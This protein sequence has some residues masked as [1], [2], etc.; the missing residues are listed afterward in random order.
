MTRVAVVT[1]SRAD[2]AIYRPV[3][4]ALAD[5]PGIDPVLV[6]VGMHLSAAHGETVR[7]IE[8]DGYPI[9]ARIP[10]PLEDDTPGGTTR[11]TAAALEGY[12]AWLERDRPD[13]LVVL[14][15]RY[16][17]HAAALAALPAKVPVVHLHGGERTEGAFDEALRHGITK[18]AHLHCAATSEAAA[19]IRQLGE[20]PWR[21]TITGAP[22]IDALLAAPTI[23]AA[24]LAA[25]VGLPPA[26]PPL[27]VTHHPATLTADP[28]AEVDELLAALG[29]V[30]HPVL[31][32]APNADPQ[33]RAVR[34][35]IEAFVAGRASAVLV[36]NL[37]HELFASVLSWAAAMVGNSS[38]GLIEAPTFGLPVVNV[39]S[40]QDGRMRGAN[41][42]DVEPRRDAIA[43]GIRRALEPAFRASLAGAPN[44]Y[45]DGQAGPRIAALLSSVVL[46]DHLVVKRFCDLDVV[47][48]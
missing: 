21:V 5:A 44:P 14:G 11:A 39:G 37:G 33:G 45:G 22:G 36:T 30:D 47:P 17:M 8:A 41:V 15:D 46:D 9:A 13:L 34:A 32:T 26:P 31:F 18:L 6:V 27:L 28:V 19:R 24:D 20:E 16:E 29:D 23:S 2:Y 12:A 3:L 42:I 38:S 10:L 4:R 1:T 25:R 43:A 40:R 48:A 35:R 7:D